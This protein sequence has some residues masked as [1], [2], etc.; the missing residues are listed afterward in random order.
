[1]IH[2]D[3]CFSYVGTFNYPLPTCTTLYPLRFSQEIGNKEKAWIS[4]DHLG[5]SFWREREITSI[6]TGSDRV[7]PGVGGVSHGRRHGSLRQVGSGL[8]EGGDGEGAAAGSG[9]E[10]CVVGS[11]GF[12]ILPLRGGHGA[13]VH[14]ALNEVGAERHEAGDVFSGQSVHGVSRARRGIIDLRRS[15][16]S[17][18]RLR[19]IGRAGQ[20]RRPC[21][22][23]R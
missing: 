4:M 10:S 17:R 19:G 21:R 12:V 3:P 1:M 9:D 13:L 5:G 8:A 7:R 11:P 20:S 6:N 22:S 15:A 18:T 14:G 23:R 16:G 2:G